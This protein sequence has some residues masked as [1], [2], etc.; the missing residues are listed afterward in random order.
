[1]KN[2]RIEEET[3]DKYINDTLIIVTGDFR[4]DL[5]NKLSNKYLNFTPEQLL[6]SFL[7]YQFSLQDHHL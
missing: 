1:M 3:D 5:K 7:F 2:C 4:M 6:R